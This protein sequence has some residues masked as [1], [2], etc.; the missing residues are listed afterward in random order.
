MSVVV[1]DTD[2]ASAVL[3]RRARRPL[4]PGAAEQVLTFVTV[5]ELTKWTLL[6]R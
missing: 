3:Q 2:V 1:R 5:G 4:P 6:S